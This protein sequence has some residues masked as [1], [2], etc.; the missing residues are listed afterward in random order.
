LSGVENCLNVSKRSGLLLVLLDELEDAAA[1]AAVVAEL[2]G[3]VDELDAAL[4]LGGADSQAD[5]LLLSGLC[6]GKKELEDLVSR[7]IK[8]EWIH[9]R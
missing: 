5:V 3:G 1:A 2:D 9:R 8:L 6:R 4:V 7:D